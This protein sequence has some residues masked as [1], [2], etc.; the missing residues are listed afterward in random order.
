MKSYINQHRE[1]RGGNTED[2]YFMCNFP[3]FSVSISVPSVFNCTTLCVLCGLKKILRRMGKGVWSV[4]G[5]VCTFDI[6]LQMYKCPNPTPTSFPS[7]FFIQGR[8]RF[9]LL[10]FGLMS[11]WRAPRSFQTGVFILMNVAQVCFVSKT[12]C[13]SI[14][15]KPQVVFLSEY[16]QKNIP[17]LHYLPIYTLKG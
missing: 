12:T 7:S 3:V 16:R 15:F 11:G 2:S 1:H 4:W 17:V 14:I 9:M 6:W 10:L 13:D 5:R 8:R